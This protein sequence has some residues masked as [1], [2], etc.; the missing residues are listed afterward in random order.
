[1][2]P[3]SLK[4]INEDKANLL[5]ARHLK[6]Q[7]GYYEYHFNYGDDNESYEFIYTTGIKQ[8]MIRKFHGQCETGPVAQ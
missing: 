1:M 6:N 7:T 5:I 3:K 2:I 8:Y 4:P